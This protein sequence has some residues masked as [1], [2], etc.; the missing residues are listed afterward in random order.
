MSR[1]GWRRLGEDQETT[2]LGKKMPQTDDEWLTHVL[3][4]HGLFLEKYIRKTADEMQMQQECFV[5][6]QSFGIPGGEVDLWLLAFQEDV[7]QLVASCVIECK[8]HEPSLSRWIFFE[9]DSRGTKRA[10]EV[11]W[12]SDI[13]WDE[14]NELQSGRV[15]LRPSVFDPAVSV[16]FDAHE[17]RSSYPRKDAAVTKTGTARIQDAILQL[18]KGVAWTQ[19]TERLR[20]NQQGAAKRWRAVAGVPIVVTTARLSV[21]S[22]DDSLLDHTG[23]LPLEGG[24]RTRDVPWVLY[25]HPNPDA[26]L[27]P[28]ML[29]PRAEFEG[30]ARFWCFVVR[31]EKFR[32]LILQLKQWR[33][34]RGEME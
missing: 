19:E 15:V 7:G 22:I 12:F 14:S 16:T 3:N 32:E 25:G 24:I 26:E 28:R 2:A 29:A 9:A 20:Q 18:R 8:K 17:V 6:A 23:D 31:A 1:T 33:A 21:A 10:A 27:T 5:R 11:P 4:I 34:F 30:E 13:Y